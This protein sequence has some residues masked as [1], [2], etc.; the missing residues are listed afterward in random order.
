[1]TQMAY[2]TAPEI[3]G[4]L[5]LNKGFPWNENEALDDWTLEPLEIPGEW[6]GSTHYRI[7]SWDRYVYILEYNVNL[8]FDN[9]K[10]ESYIIRVEK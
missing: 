1:M 6:M 2:I 9:K 4:R 3:L 10:L 5:F 8:A 7:K